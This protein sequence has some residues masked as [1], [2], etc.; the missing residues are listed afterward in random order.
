MRREN[1]ALE[2]ARG[3]VRPIVTI[4]MAVAVVA[5]FFT[6][7]IP[8]DSFMTIAGTAIL[9]WFATRQRGGT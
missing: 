9:F 7:H 6:G 2:L 1:D 5:G 4:V 3:L 8:A